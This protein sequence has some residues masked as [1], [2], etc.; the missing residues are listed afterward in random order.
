MLENEL[1]RVKKRLARKIRL[2][3]REKNLTQGDLA[4]EMGVSQPFVSK[5]EKGESMPGKKTLVRISRALDL[6]DKYFFDQ[7]SLDV[8]DSKGKGKSNEI[9]MR[10]KNIE[11][12]VSK[13]YTK[14]KLV[15]LSSASWDEDETVSEI[16][17]PVGAGECFTNDNVIARHTL[18]R[19]ITYGATHMLRVQGRSMEPYVMEGDL[20]LV[21]PQKHIEH[22]GQLAVVNIGN[23][24]NSVKFVY[25]EGDRVG[26]GRSIDEAKWQDKDEVR[27]QG[28]VV[29]K[30]SSYDVIRDYEFRAKNP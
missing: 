16:E 13:G 14:N 23:H 3:R 21:V 22:N 4:R 17:F 7:L 15:P 11:D 27:I 12:M 2:A 24:A 30:I 18:P 10:L 6:D 19:N 8:T 9:L 20:L 25:I 29:S 1:D 5:I 28:I 26:I